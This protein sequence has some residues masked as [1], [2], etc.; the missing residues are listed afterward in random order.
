MR[1]SQT[2]MR[3]ID[4]IIPCTNISSVILAMCMYSSNTRVC[5]MK[6]NVYIL[7]REQFM[8]LAYLQSKVRLLKIELTL[9]IKLYSKG[10]MVYVLCSIF[11]TWANRVPN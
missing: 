4:S 2:S 7:A 10:T 6:I 8:H 1:I 9:A 11:T 3:R 5:R